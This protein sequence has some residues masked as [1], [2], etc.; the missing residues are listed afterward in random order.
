MSENYIENKSGTKINLEDGTI[1]TKNFK[2]NENG[3][4][5][6]LNGAKIIGDNGLMTTYMQEA[7][8][9]ETGN[10]VNII[11]YY[12]DYSSYSDMKQKLCINILIPDGYEITRARV[13]GYHTPVKWSGLD[14]TATWGYIRNL[15]IY[16]ASNINNVM[17]SENIDSEFLMSDN[18]S[19]EEVV[20]AFGSSGSTAQKP[21]D[22]SHI[23]EK[24]ETGDIKNIF[25]NNEKTIPGLYQIIMESS[26]AFNKSWTKAQKAER[27]AYCPSVMLIVEGYMTYK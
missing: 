13:I 2:V 24:F 11:G 4:V 20:E 21:S 1:D 8:P 23:T 18:F 5:S 26:E 12:S 6:L 22:V 15:K 16:K 27:T 19:Y 9:R 3:D 7:K 10:T 17:I 14:M 25:K